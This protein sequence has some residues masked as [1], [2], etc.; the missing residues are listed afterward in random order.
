VLWEKVPDL[1]HTEPLW[2]ISAVLSVTRSLTI[3]SF[4]SGHHCDY[5]FLMDKAFLQVTR[6]R[7][8]ALSKSLAYSGH[9]QTSTSPF[10]DIEVVSCPVRFQISFPIFQYCLFMVFLSSFCP[11]SFSF[12]LFHICLIKSDCSAKDC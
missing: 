3:S 7:N 5:L 1:S 12:G 4:F 8:N 10:R 9:R 11:S 2:A 6:H